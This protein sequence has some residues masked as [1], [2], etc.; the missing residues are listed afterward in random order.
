MA[1]HCAARL[2]VGG[3]L[4]DECGVD[5]FRDVE[6]ALSWRQPVFLAAGLGGITRL[7]AAGVAARPWAWHPDAVPSDLV[8]GAHPELVEKLVQLNGFPWVGPGQDLEWNFLQGDSSSPYL[9]NG[10][11]PEEN[12]QLEHT[13]NPRVLASLTARGLSRLAALTEQ[14]P[15]AVP[16]WNPSQNGSP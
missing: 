11:L 5:F 7:I 3:G 9:F 6:Y 16:F 13:R 1:A 14:D 2:V 12:E 15:A 8:E 4:P 10:L